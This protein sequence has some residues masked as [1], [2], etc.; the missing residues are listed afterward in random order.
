MATESTV[1]VSGPLFDGTAV[2]E[3]HQFSLDAV[4][5]VSQQAHAEWMTN[6]DESIK[7]P[8]PYYETQINIREEAPGTKVVNDRGVIYGWW[9]EGIGSRNAPVTRF[10]GYF[11][12]RKAIVQTGAKT[13]ALL[14]RLLQPYLERMRGGVE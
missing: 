9:L 13:P 10:R 6:L 4:D 11:A 2:R 12:R 3:V 7:H 5:Q 14:E 1:R 8:T